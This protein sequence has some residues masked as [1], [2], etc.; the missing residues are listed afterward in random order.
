MSFSTL[1]LLDT[2][3]WIWWAEQEPRLPR[4]L[5]E[6]IENHEGVVA[7]SSATIY[8]TITL[9][10][11]QRIKLNYETGDWL[12]RATY[13]AGIEV[14]PLD[15]AIARM[16]GLLPFHHGDPL[17]R[18]IIATAICHDGQLASLDSQF[19]HYEE[20]TGRLISGKE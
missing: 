17:D 16:A 5:K 7:I 11:K 8:E 15:A 20:L 9:V 10:R 18:L 3:A 12:H 19:P 6:T 4:I 2:H 14:I 13:G 1:L